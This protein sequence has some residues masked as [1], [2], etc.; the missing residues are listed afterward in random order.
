MLRSLKCHDKVVDI[1]GFSYCD[2]AML[3]EYVSFSFACIGIEHEVVSTMKGLLDACDAISSF[4][5]FQHTQMHLANDVA[6]GLGFLHSHNVA[7]RDLKPANVLVSNS[8]YT[9]SSDVTSCWSVR[10]VIA[11]LSDFGESRSSMLQTRSSLNSATARLNRG[12]PAYMAPEAPAGNAFTVAHMDSL[13]AMD[14]WSFAMI[15]LHLLNLNV[16]YPSAAEMDKK[17]KD[18]GHLGDAKTHP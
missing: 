1:H 16:R 6:A 5:G 4:S 11:K 15:L 7:H 9:A 10:P 3:L 14:V 17:P 12:S 18:L 2:K 13:L 8:H